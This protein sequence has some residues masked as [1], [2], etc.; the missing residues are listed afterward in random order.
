VKNFNGPAHVG[1]SGGGINI[2]NVTGKIDAST[3]GGSVAA[4]FSSP[5]SE[6]VKLGT[7]GGGV[8]LRVPESSA[9]DLDASTSGGSVNCELPVA[10][11]GKVAHNHMKGPVNVGGKPVVLRTS[12]GSIHVK[13]G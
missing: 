9:F 12:G 2:E 8:T 13:K 5:L 7:S 4:K 11:T 3:T 10:V 6:E 1:S